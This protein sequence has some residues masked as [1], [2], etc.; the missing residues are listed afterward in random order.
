MSIYLDDLSPAALETLADL[1]EQRLEN[2]QSHLAPVTWHQAQARQ[3]AVRELSQAM[4]DADP[5]WLPGPADSA[6]D[7]PLT[8]H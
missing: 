1:I 8:L 3:N 2:D 5:A 7:Q 4:A 6:G